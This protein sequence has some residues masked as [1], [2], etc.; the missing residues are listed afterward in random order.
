MLKSLLEAIDSEVPNG[1]QCDKHKIQAHTF[2]FFSTEDGAAVLAL[3][4]DHYLF[5]AQ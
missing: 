5:R 3:S 1:W 2:H 4:F